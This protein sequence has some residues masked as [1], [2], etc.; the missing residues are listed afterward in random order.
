LFRAPDGTGRT[1]AGRWGRARALTAAGVLVLLAAA[2]GCKDPVENPP[3][4]GQEGL[5]LLFRVPMPGAVETYA[6][7]TDGTRLY[8]DVDKHIEAFDLETGARRWSYARPRGGPSALVAAGGRVMFAADTAVALDAATGHELWRRPLPAFAGF[9]E[10]D[11]TADAFY[12]GTQER[13]VYAL[14]AA[15]GSVLWERDLGPDWPYKGVVRGMTVSGDTVYA[16]VEHDTGVNGHVGTG[17]TFALDR[18]TGA[19]L[20]HHRF[21]DGSGLSIYQSAGRVAGAMLLNTANW[22][23]TFVALDR[24]TGQEVWR[25]VGGT[26]FLGP[27]EAPEV[28][29]GVAYAAAHD[30]RARAISLADGRVLW[31]VPMRGGA[32]YMALCGKVMLANYL[33]VGAFDQAT[34]A[35]LGEAKREPDAEAVHTDFVV[36]GNRAYVF[37]THA[38]LAFRCPT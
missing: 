16:V 35:F 24:F 38:L 9:C 36:V 32:I 1:N 8:A 30:Q 21:G 12:L 33:R 31:D 20:W 17:D 3:P 4:G 25:L 15:D 2:G 10:T 7:A 26:E 29:G 23:N 28:R 34:G 22:E 18:R 13:R 37:S 19:V 11:G 14:S 27:R 6:P 5:E